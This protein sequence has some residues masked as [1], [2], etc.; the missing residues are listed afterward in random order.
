MLAFRRILCIQ[1]NSV[2]GEGSEGGSVR[3]ILVQNI[4]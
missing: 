1:W 4:P 2:A 3:E